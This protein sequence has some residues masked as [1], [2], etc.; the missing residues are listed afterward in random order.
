[1]ACKSRVLGWIV[2]A[3]SFGWNAV[4]FGAEQKP[5]PDPEDPLKVVG[6]LTCGL[7]GAG[8]S[9][10]AGFGREMICHFQP[11]ERGPRETYVGSVQGVGKPE[12]LFGKG[13]VL[14]AVK[15]PRSTTLSA[16]VLAQTYA[17]DAASSGSA[18]APLFG[19]KNRLI[20]LQPL[21]EQ[22]GR[23]ASGKT[24]PDAVIILVELRLEA[25]PA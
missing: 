14:L 11:G 25:A 10:T 18:F 7:L 17:V 4:L 13:A 2:L 21:A 3:A 1:M 16:G 15:A 19:D 23:V 5:A 6:L 24:Q 12:L 8:K 22:E 20:I 9:A